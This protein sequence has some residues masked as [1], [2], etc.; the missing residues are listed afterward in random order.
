MIGASRIL[1]WRGFTSQPAVWG[2]FS[3]EIFRYNI[4]KTYRF[5]G[6]GRGFE[7]LKPKGGCATALFPLYCL[8]TH[9]FFFF[10]SFFSLFSFFLRGGNLIRLGFPIRSSVRC[11]TP[12]WTD[13]IV[14]CRKSKKNIFC[15][16]IHAS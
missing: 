6:R 2:K 13:V 10:S 5:F 12:T 8:V 11:S 15:F 9:F 3:L 1:F 14:I 4:V 16:T 7:P